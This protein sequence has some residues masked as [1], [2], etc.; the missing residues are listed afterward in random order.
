MSGQLDAPAAVPR[1]NRWVGPWTGPDTVVKKSSS[2]RE[3]NP[4]SCISSIFLFLSLS[5][6]YLQY[7]PL[8]LHFYPS[9]SNSF[10][11]SSFS[12]FAILILYFLAFFLTCTI[13]SNSKFLFTCPFTEVAH[14]FWYIQN[15]SFNSQLLLPES[16]KANWAAHTNGKSYCFRDH[17]LYTVDWANDYE[18]SVIWTN[19]VQNLGVLQI[20]AATTGSCQT[21]SIDLRMAVPFL[22]HLSLHLS[23]FRNIKIYIELLVPYSKAW[24]GMLVWLN[25]FVSA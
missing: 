10:C 9:L 22:W 13:N 12:P 21:V 3:S 8:F 19:R 1:G 6:L 20:C 2:C 17:I 11:L 25:N 5:A 7:I 23:R 15:N 24:T 14:I 18:V 16:S 4:D